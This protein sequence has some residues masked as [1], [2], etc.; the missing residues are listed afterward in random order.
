MSTPDKPIPPRC[1]GCG[2]RTTTPCGRAV[3]PNR[4]PVTAAIPDGS[5]NTSLTTG[6]SWRSRLRS[7]Q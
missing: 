1:A 4:K 2:S 6:V 7:D 5:V 3:C